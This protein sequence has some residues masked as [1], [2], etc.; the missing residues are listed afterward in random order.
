MGGWLGGRQ[1]ICRRVQP[2]PAIH[3][4][5]QDQQNPTHHTPF[6]SLSFTNSSSSCKGRVGGWGRA[7]VIIS[8]RPAQPLLPPRRRPS[9]GRLSASSAPEAAGAYGQVVVSRHLQSSGEAFQKVRHCP[10]GGVAAKV[11]GGG[12]RTF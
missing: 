11:A 1:R 5:P 12:S 10:L 8:N 6:S 4:P 2:L 3:P 7:H 9:L